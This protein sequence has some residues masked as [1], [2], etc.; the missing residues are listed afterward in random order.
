M[1]DGVVAGVT[2]GV[3]AGIAIAAINAVSQEQK[4]ASR[5]NSRRKRS[6]YQRMV[7]G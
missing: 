6:S 7:W 2:A 4:R 1:I 5:N 3:T